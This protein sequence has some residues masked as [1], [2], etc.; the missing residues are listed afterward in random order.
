MNAKPQ[1]SRYEEL[2]S[3]I[4]F[5]NHRYHVLD[6]PVISDVEYDRLLNELKQIEAAQP[7]W[8]TPDSPTQRAGSAPSERFEKVSHP[9]PILSLANAFGAA[10]ARAWFERVRKLDERVGKA[11]FVVEPKIDGLSVVLH[12][13]NGLFVQGATRGDGEIGEDI[14]SNLRTVRTIPLKIP[15]TQAEDLKVP[16]YLVVRGEA[17]I[18][19]KEFEELNQQLEEAGQKTYLNPRNTAA[20]SLRQLDPS[21]TASRPLTLLVYQIIHSEGGKVPTSQ[22]GLL[23]YLKKLGFPVTDVARQFSDI[24]SAIAYTETWNTRR[25]ELTYEADGMVIKID[26]LNLA[27][28]LGVVGKDPRGAIAFKFPAREVTTKLLDIRVSVGRTGVLIPNAVLEPVEIG[29]VV[30]E[31]ATLHNFDYIAEKDIRIGDRVLVKRAGEVIPYIIGPV[32]DARKGSEKKYIP[33]KKCPDCGQPVEHFEGE[34][35]WYCVNSA[36]PAQLLRNVEHFVSRGS[37][38]IVG[39]GSKIVEKLVETDAIK[40]AADIYTLDRDDILQ[41]VTKK[42][43]KTD[44]EPPGKI[45]DNLLSSI[46]NSK[47]QSLSRLITALGI[48]GVGEVVAGDLARHFGNLDSLSKV[49]TDDLM[50]IDGVGPNIAE[51]IV[52]W[53]GRPANK[54][55]LA[56]L[57]KAGIWPRSM[58]KD[59]KKE[60]KFTGMTFVITGTLPAFSREQAKAFIEE[61]GGKVTD[62]VSKNTSY[63]LLGVEPGSKFDKARSL[64]VK[65]ISE[66]DLRKMVR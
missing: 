12:Y 44:K 42:D 15:V 34:V 24:E 55:V 43:R 61:N 25:D 45:A 47:A 59:R 57:K 38:D 8:I 26:D 19:I 56:K 23:D 11:K 13:R 41:A 33:P 58:D 49:S 14:T 16:S 4:N 36:C 37:M 31:R 9:A 51:G 30:V 1:R 65:I 35:A 3:Q 53:F 62:S 46:E 54:K 10:D 2:K 21:L 63:L 39:L 17:F 28:E 20:G 7:G 27:A 52:D 5:H 29:G 60:G 22:W 32:I 48:R 18:P 64:G 40:D 66:D 6:A 50:H